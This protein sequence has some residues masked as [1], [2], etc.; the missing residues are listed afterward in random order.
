[1]YQSAI[2][3]YLNL[4][5]NQVRPTLVEIFITRSF[6]DHVNIKCEQNEQILDKSFS[7]I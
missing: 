3:V 2:T 1:M 7:E 4:N 6:H 5:R